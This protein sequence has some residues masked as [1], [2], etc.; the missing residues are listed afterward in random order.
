M[1]RRDHL[2]DD[3]AHLVEDWKTEVANDDTRI[4]NLDW[5]EARMEMIWEVLALVPAS[6]AHS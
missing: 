5:A 6:P 4:G 3:S 2:V 1:R